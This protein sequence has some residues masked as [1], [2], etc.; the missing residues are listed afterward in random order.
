MEF[1]ILSYIL[2]GIIALLSIVFILVFLSQNKKIKENNFSIKKTLKK[3]EDEINYTKAE[4]K[5][6]NYI[7]NDYQSKLFQKQQNFNETQEQHKT[8]T[9]QYK[10]NN[11][12]IIRQQNI[13]ENEKLKFKDKTKRL[14]EQ[15]IAIHKEKEKIDNQRKQIVKTHQQVTDSIRYAKNIQTALLPPKAYFDGTPLDYFIFFKPRDI[16]SG[17]FYWIRKNKQKLI[18]VAADCTGHGVPGAFMSMLGI[19]AL[20]DIVS[21]NMDI[22]PAEILE[23]LRQ[24][25][26]KSLR[27]GVDVFGSKDG[28]DAAICVFDFS[29]KTVEYAGAYNPLYM[30][31]DGELSEYKA[32]KNPVA[33]YIK[34]K[35]FVN[36][37]IKY[38]E[39]DFFYIF[40]DGYIDQFGGETRRK[41]MSANF[42][43]LLKKL[44]T[45]ETTMEKIHG[46]LDTEFQEWKSDRH[47]QLD[48]VLVIGLKT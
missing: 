18:V 8:S 2:L 43:K 46:K 27:Q 20:N 28:M 10:G 1:N 47:E 3:Y 12:E 48:D 25:V 40:S 34:M 32:V 9:E 37:R 38:K 44:S 19:S 30:I 5:R 24:F 17:D 29:Q 11:E 21:E 31:R 14:W 41:Y 13:L 4:I 45:T 39:N 36:N 16:V 35:P 7:I 42:K 26:I 22:S 33:H 6:Q 23:Q 15:S